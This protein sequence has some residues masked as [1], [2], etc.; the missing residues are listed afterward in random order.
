MLN[1]TGKAE[2]YWVATLAGEIPEYPS[3]DGDLAVDVAI[4]GGGIV[5]LTAAELLAR[6]GKRVALIEALKLGQQVTG[7]S[8]AKVTS[9]HGLIYQ[10]LVKEFGEETARAYGAANQAGLEQIARYVR[11][12]EIDC[13]LERAAAYVY[14]CSD[15]EVAEIER[16]VETAK[17]LDLPASFVRDVPLP[18]PTAGAVRFDDQAQFNP[19]NTALAWR[20]PLPGSA[21]SSS[22][23]PGRARSSTASPAGS[24]VSAAS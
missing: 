7:R 5:G 23:I 19:L 24:R 6:A 3:L 1:L 21:N 17:K 8:T 10:Q 13:E 20:E 11:D 12:G 18:F 14:A 22:R 4:V 15:A 9:Q 2:S 16:E